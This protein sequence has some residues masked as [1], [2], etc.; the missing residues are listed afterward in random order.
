MFLRSLKMSLSTPVSLAGRD[1]LYAAARDITERK[2]MEEALRAANEREHEVAVAFHLE[3]TESL[4][5]MAGAIAHHFNNKLQTVMGNLEMVLDDLPQNDESYKYLLEA[6]SAAE[7]ASEI[8]TLMLTYPGQTHEVRD[9][10]DLAET[11][12]NELPKLQ[13]LLPSH[14]VL[15]SDLSCS[16][17]IV[18]A[19]VNQIKH[20]LQNLVLNAHEAD[21]SAESTVRVSVREVPAHEISELNRFPVDW[22]ARN[23]RYACLE[24]SDKGCGIRPED[25]D[26]LFEPFFTSKFTGRGLGLS[27]VLGIVRA[28]DGGIT[29]QTE[30]GQ[31]SVFCVYLPIKLSD[32]GVAPNPDMEKEMGRTILVVDDEEMMRKI[33][34]SLL[35][36]LG[37][38]VVEAASGTQ[39]LQTFREYPGTIHGVVCDQRM[40][41]MGGWEVLAELRKIKPDIPVI[42]VSGYSQEQPVMGDMV[43]RPQAYLIKPFRREQ[44]RAAMD[45]ALPNA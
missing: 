37:F 17:L 20:I 5:R 9:S 43:E 18:G 13:L 27:V 24:V 4:G 39:A 34:S 36:D 26:K 31:G 40:P 16:G 11:C 41:Q 8:S 21:D 29:V 30:P 14:R 42:M 33:A 6:M 12:R 19:A 32:P 2:R 22:C 25:V 44:L 3:K 45:K 15:E 28:H 38:N 1:Y 10:L 35:E 7:R 23:D